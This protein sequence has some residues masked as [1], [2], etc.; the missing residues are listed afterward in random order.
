LGVVAPAQQTADREFSF[1]ATGSALWRQRQ[2]PHEDFSQG[3]AR[4]VDGA[5][6]QLRLPVGEAVT[7]SSFNGPAIDLAVDLEFQRALS[8][9]RATSSRPKYIFPSPMIRDAGS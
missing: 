3:S 7:D 1:K 4:L 2:R 5:P 8:G 6:G 9:V